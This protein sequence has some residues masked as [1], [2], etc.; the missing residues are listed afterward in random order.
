MASLYPGESGATEH[1]ESG[2]T[3]HGATASLEGHEARPVLLP[4]ADL[5]LLKRAATRK[6][7]LHDMMRA[8]LN[9]VAAANPQQRDGAA[10][11]RVEPPADLP[12]MEYVAKHKEAD[13]I[14]GDGLVSFSLCFIAGTRD[15]NRNGQMRLD[16][17]VE[18]MPRDGA[19]EHV[20]L[21]P[22]PKGPRSDAKVR[23][24]SAPADSWVSDKD[25]ALRNLLG[26]PQHLRYGKRQAWASLNRILQDVPAQTQVELTVGATEDGELFPYWL[27]LTNLGEVSR[28]LHVRCYTYAVVK[29]T[30][31][32]HPVSGVWLHV[33]YDDGNHIDLGIYRDPR[34][35]KLT[36]YTTPSWS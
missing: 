27:W 30:C 21:H 9:E 25:A 18:K 29:A 7:D 3:E 4:R 20:Y 17:V 2:A 36:V 26:I 6:G 10:P 11:M 8:W 15:P 34:Y 22:G 12:W 16:Y 1:G 32:W 19:T 35:G 24:V 13:R 28:D 23:S 14:V 5:P 33:H 31:E